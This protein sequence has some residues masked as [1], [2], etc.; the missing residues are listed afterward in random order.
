MEKFRKI[1]Y[2]LYFP[3]LNKPNFGRNK[4][5]NSPI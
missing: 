1:F 2:N 5:V 3:F 4:L